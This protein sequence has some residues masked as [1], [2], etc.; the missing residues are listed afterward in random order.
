MQAANK[1][2]AIMRVQTLDDH[3]L[4]GF[5]HPIAELSATAKD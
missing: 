3:K 4:P 2:A 5:S 1:L